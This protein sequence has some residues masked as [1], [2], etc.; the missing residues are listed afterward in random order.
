MSGLKNRGPQLGG[1][2]DKMP[3]PPAA[4]RAK[5]AREVLSVWIADT[6][7]EVVLQPAFDDPMVW[8]LL[9][10][11]VARHVSRMFADDTGMSEQEALDRL[12]VGWN[13]E[14]ANPTDLG[15]TEKLS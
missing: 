9:L 3:V 12:R 1:G 4:K 7:A 15:S 5:E 14:I 10:V 6:R 2:P 8:G 13:A 11:D